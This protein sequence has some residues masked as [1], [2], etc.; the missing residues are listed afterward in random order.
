MSVRYKGAIL[1][2][3]IADYYKLAAWSKN[4]NPI[5]NMDMIGVIKGQSIGP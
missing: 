3:H 1:V 4:F 5:P 2:L